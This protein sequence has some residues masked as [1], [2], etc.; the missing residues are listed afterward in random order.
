MS[1]DT[2]VEKLATRSKDIPD[3][4]YLV[5]AINEVTVQEFGGRKPS[6]YY[7]P[8][9]LDKCLR[10]LY[11]KRLGV[12][13]DPNPD[14]EV[15]NC[16]KAESGEDRHER[17]Q[18]KIVLASDKYDFDIVWVDVEKFIKRR[19]LDYLEVV[20]KDEY[21]VLLLDNRFDLRFRIDGLVKIKGRYYIIEIKTDNPD[22]WQRRTYVSKWHNMQGYCYALSLQ[23][24]TIIYLY[25]E[26]KDFQKQPLVKK[27]SEEEKQ[28]VV[29]KINKTEDYIQ[30]EELPPK[31]I[32]KCMFCDYKIKCKE[33]Y[34]PK[35]GDNN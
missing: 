15:K 24:D 10:S 8:S 5:N 6:T 4:E 16:E 30:N 21:E 14:I 7:S 28:K 26:R 20:F 27:V 19:G 32:S 25:E 13:I 2:L 22:F 9:G 33:N 18:Q 12:D 23:L 31:D 1:L 35:E 29:E 3:E 11:Y 34:N 17:I